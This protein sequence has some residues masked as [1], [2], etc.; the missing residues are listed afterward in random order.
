MPDKVLKKKQ[1]LFG[2]FQFDTSRVTRKFQFNRCSTST[3][4]VIHCIYF[5]F[6]V[7]KKDVVAFYLYQPTFI[8]N[9]LKSNGEMLRKCVYILKHFIDLISY[10][11][12]QLSQIFF[13]SPKLL[14][15]I[16]IYSGFALLINSVFM[17]ASCNRS[18]L[19][20]VT[21]VSVFECS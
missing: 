4:R 11:T 14:R 12:H 9:F 20:L 10:G 5:N 19:P 7:F 15:H 1:N 6:P 2:K 16:F 3:R 8:F 17:V 21:S 13:V 18:F